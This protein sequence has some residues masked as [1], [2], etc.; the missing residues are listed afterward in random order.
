MKSCGILHGFDLQKIATPRIKNIKANP[1]PGEPITTRKTYGRAWPAGALRISFKGG[2]V[3][4]I[5]MMKNKPAI[6]EIGTTSESALGRSTAGSRHSS[7]IE[8]I[9]PIAA[10]VYAAGSRPMKK[11]KPPHPE[12]VLL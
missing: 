9:I 2:S 3:A 11:L 12:R 4:Q 1:P 5:G 8:L 6:P 10:K 7:A